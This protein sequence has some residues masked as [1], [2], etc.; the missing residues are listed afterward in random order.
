MCYTATDLIKEWN[1]KRGYRAVLYWLELYG[2]DHNL[3]K[4]FLHAIQ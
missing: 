3:R 1:D 4:L 2:S